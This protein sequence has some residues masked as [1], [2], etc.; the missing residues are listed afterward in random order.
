MTTASHPKYKNKCDELRSDLISKAQDAVHYLAA[1]I[2]DWR[3]TEFESTFACTEREQAL[4]GRLESYDA[5]KLAFLQCCDLARSIADELNLSER[6]RN[7][8]FNRIPNALDLVD[9]DY[10]NSEAELK[11]EAKKAFRMFQKW[12]ACLRINAY[13]CTDLMTGEQH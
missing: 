7:E 9:A 11:R 13:D 2:N 3:F 12:M 6:E 1:A 5:G 10:I 4:R 8:P